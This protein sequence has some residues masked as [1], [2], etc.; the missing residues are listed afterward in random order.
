MLAAELGF[1][2]EPAVVVEG[3]GGTRELIQSPPLDE[4]K[5]A[6]AQVR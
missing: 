2:A 3:P 5:A 4:V 1:P 6:I